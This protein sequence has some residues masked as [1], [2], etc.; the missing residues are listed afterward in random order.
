MKVRDMTQADLA[1]ATGLSKP[2]I[3]QYVNGTYE[4]KQQALYV[5]AEVLKVN[6]SYQKGC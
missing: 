3:S 5:L 6:I 4:A 2:R 1:K